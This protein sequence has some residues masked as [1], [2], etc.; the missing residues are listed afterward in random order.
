LN[1]D[2]VTVTSFVREP[3]TIY[4][5]DVR[6]WAEVNMGQYGWVPVDVIIDPTKRPKPKESRSVNEEDQKA[7]PPNRV[8]LPESP[9]QQPVNAKKPDLT[10]P[11]PRHF[12]I[13][14]ILVITGISLLLPVLLFGAILL[15]I[16]AVKHR[17]RQQRRNRSSP[18]AAIGGA[19]EELLERAWEV[20]IR[21]PRYAT[22]DEVGE[23]VSQARPDTNVRAIGDAV[24][25]AAFQL[26]PPSQQQRDQ[27]W[28]NVDA[29]VDKW[30]SALTKWQ[31]FR[32]RVS[33]HSFRAVKGL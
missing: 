1:S 9:Q 16:G 33:L 29:T 23:A 12:E 31:R 28:Q 2:G 14:R 18:A 22:I 21:F 7:S 13:P 8:P 3:N 19:W 27:T 17:R 24:E 15:V 11:V 5:R 4:G 32:I 26:D 20:G 30:H 10:K 25:R 6:A